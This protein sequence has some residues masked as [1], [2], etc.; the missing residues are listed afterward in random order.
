MG[1]LGKGEFLILIAIAR[2]LFQNAVTIHIANSTVSEYCLP[3]S[4]PAAG[5]STVFNFC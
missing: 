5:G 3:A 4:L 2:L 1:F